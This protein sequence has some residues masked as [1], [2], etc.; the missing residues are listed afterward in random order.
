MGEPGWPLEKVGEERGAEDV[1]GSAIENWAGDA[2]PQEK[3]EKR[4]NLRLQGRG[5]IELERGGGDATDGNM[6]R[7]A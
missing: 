2:E 7:M 1:E 4:E 3:V 5:L 6:V